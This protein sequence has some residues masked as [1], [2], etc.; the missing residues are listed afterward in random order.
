MGETGDDDEAWDAVVPD[1]TVIRA[2]AQDL[3]ARL[4]LAGAPL[5]R[6]PDGSQPVYAVGDELVLELFPS[7]AAQDGVAEGRVLS[8][9]H[10]LLPVPTP[11]VHDFGAYENGWQYML[12]SRL[13][14]ENLAPAWDRMAR[15]GH[16]F[17]PAGLL[18]YTLLHV[19]SNLPW[20]LRELAGPADGTL[21]ALAEA[22]F[23]AA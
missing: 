11:K 1:E 5:S 3:C 23:A 15:Y 16:A 20:Y 18:A 8:H 19:Y 4:G 2:G 10:G 9:L 12:M 6:F 17:E 7:A 22:W 21:P 13:P 14:G